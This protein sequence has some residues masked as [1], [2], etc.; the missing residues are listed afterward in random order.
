MLSDL[1]VASAWLTLTFRLMSL[2]AMRGRMPLWAF[3]LL[4][5]IC[6]VMLGIACACAADNSAQTIDRAVS[7]ISGAPAVVEVW[8]FTFSALVVLVAFDLGRR[9]A[10]R[11]RSPAVLQ[12]FLF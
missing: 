9:R 12:C 3:I 1:A 8:T 7:T 11:A 6:L 5:L 4:A 10:S 2:Q